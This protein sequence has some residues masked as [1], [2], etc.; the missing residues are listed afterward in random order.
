MS[1]AG[2]QN[3]PGMPEPKAQTQYGLSQRPPPEHPLVASLRANPQTPPA[4]TVTV[5]GL[6]GA[7]DDPAKG[8]VYLSS[9]LDH[10]AEFHSDDVVHY[11][12][13]PAAQSPIPGYDTTRVTVKRGSSVTYA[14]SVTAD[15]QFDLDVRLGTGMASASSPAAEAAKPR[16]TYLTQCGTCDTCQTCQTCL[17]CLA[18]CGGRTMG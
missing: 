3:Q 7:S 10:Y 4:P 14:R 17:T 12:T 18:D 6:F 8:R 16:N 5:T 1:G 9:Q 13:I 15:D 2:E 11:E